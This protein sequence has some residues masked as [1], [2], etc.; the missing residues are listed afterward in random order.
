MYSAEGAAMLAA[1]IAREEKATG[2]M[3]ARGC[4]TAAATTQV[5]A[6]VAYIQFFGTL[7]VFRLRAGSSRLTGWSAGVA[8]GLHRQRKPCKHLRAALMQ[9][10][11]G[12][13]PHEIQPYAYP[14]Q[15]HVHIDQ[16][17]S[18]TNEY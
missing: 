14:T 2:K 18:P 5:G 15:K 3:R 1:A 17:S 7:E 13:L 10:R 8:K 9:V 16:D 12:R 11:E 4:A 6:E